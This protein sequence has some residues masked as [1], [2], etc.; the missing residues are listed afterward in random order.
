MLR[1]VWIASSL[2]FRNLPRRSWQS[3]VIVVGMGCVIGV[4]LSMLSMTEGLYQSARKMGAPGLALVVSMGAQSE[5][6][7]SIP[8]DQARTVMDAPGIARAADGSALADPQVIVGLSAL[9]RKNDGKTSIALM[10]VGPKGLVL[11]PELHLVSGRMFRA[12][13]RELIVGVGAQGRFQNMAVGD[14]VILPDGEWPIV[15]SFVTGDIQESALIGDAETVMQAIRHP[16]FHAVLAK[17]ASPDSLA[18]FH[19]SLT[20]NPALRVDAMWQRDWFIKSSADLFTMF[21]IIVYG[22]GVILAVGA[23]FGCFNTMYA[24]VDA[25]TG[26]IATLRA[27]GF[28]GIAVAMSV[29]LEATALSLAGAL[30]GAGY[31]WLRYDGVE[32]GFNSNVF[33][34]TVSPSMVGIAILWAVSIA[35][36]GGLL[37]SIRAARL[38]VAEALRPT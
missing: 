23:L 14:K 8:R 11:R 5:G 32:T 7:S 20:T 9:L 19:R 13:R 16:A 38:T 37:P 21:D 12:G 31:A 27:L 2:N 3:L 29:L 1:Q 28:G 4:L 36:L 30:I 24:A 15:G 6:Q 25:R 35:V 22:V 17:M 10:G 26:E 18:T 34:L 33:K